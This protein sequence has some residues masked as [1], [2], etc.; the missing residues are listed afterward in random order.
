[1]VL[2][3]RILDIAYSALIKDMACRSGEFRL[4][5]IHIGGYQADFEQGGEGAESCHWLLAALAG[6]TLHRY[7][8]RSVI[9]QR[10]S[11][12]SIAALLPF[13]GRISKSTPAS[14]SVRMYCAAL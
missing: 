13:A 7:D 9:S 2:G 1:M 3:Q 11:K 12:E 10:A 6:A 4:L 14:F 5:L 8:C